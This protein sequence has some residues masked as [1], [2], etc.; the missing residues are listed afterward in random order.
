[1]SDNISGLAVLISEYEP[2]ERM[3]LLLNGQEVRDLPVDNPSTLGN[4]LYAVQDHKIPNDQV[5]AEVW[6]DGH[7]LTAERLAE[8]K[9]RPVDEFT[10]TR[11]EALPRKQLAS[12]GLRTIRQGL[13]E[14]IA[15][16]ETIVKYLCQGRSG[17]AMQYLSDYLNLWN[18]AQ[19]SVASACRLL[20][21]RLDK[22]DPNN[23]PDEIREVYQQINT[24]TS[25]LQQVKNALELGDFVL[26][27]DILNYEFI[28]ITDNWIEMLENL[29]LS[30]D[31]N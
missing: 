1:M 8:W 29:A 19:Q 22:T 16:R 5:I 14:S 20:D 15:L 30:I 18:N 25:Q 11:V 7:P 26:L 27:G 21:I 28:E 10:E 23:F 24:L 13:Q 12:N 4:T 31:T 17:N 6:V 9:H 2:G 3:K